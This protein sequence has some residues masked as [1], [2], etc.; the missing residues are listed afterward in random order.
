[1]REWL[2]SIKGV[3]KTSIWVPIIAMIMSGLLDASKGENIWKLYV[4]YAIISISREILDAIQIHCACN[5][6]RRNEEKGDVG[7]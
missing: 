4:L 7:P 3:S 1:M 6:S 2:S 5:A